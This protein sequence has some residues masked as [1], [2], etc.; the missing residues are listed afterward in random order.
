MC[1]NVSVNDGF[2]RNDTLLSMLSYNRRSGTDN[3]SV[4]TLRQAFASAG[5]IFQAIDKSSVGVIVPYGAGQSLINEIS[6]CHD[7]YKL[8]QLLR[9]AQ[10]FSV[11]VYPEKLEKLVRE[12]VIYPISEDA[13]IWGLKVDS[14]DLQTGL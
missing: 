7:I 3:N 12:G 6:A 2:N 11:S 8:K 1:Y 14:Y 9:Q 4:A 13:E 10:R 5:N